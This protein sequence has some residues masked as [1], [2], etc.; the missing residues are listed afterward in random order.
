M[1]LS[2]ITL[3]LAQ[4]L[5]IKSTVAFRAGNDGNGDLMKKALEEAL[6]VNNP[7]ETKSTSV[8]NAPPIRNK[9][10]GTEVPVS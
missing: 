8:A 1:K 3:A 6:L 9:I 2:T 4:F 5:S 7:Q 10:L